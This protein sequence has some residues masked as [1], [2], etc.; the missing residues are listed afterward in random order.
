MARADLVL[1]PSRHFSAQWKADTLSND[2]SSEATG[3]H[4]NPVSGKQ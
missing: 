4:E 3:S 2:T 1:A